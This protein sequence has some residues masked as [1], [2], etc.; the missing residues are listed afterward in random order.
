MGT[1]RPDGCSCLPKF[2]FWKEIFQPVEHLDR[3][4]VLLRRPDRCKLEQLEGS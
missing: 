2:V 4:D 3:P 1:R